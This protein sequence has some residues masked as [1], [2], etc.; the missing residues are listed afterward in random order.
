MKASFDYDEFGVLGSTEGMDSYGNIFAYTGHVY[1]DSTGIYYAKARYYDSD[2]GRFISEDSYKGEIN[3]AVTL[4]RYIYTLNNPIIY[5]DPSGNIVGIDDA[6]IFLIFAVG[7]IVLVTY[8]YLLTPAGKN[9]INSGAVA[10]YKGRVIAGKI[11][12][13][14]AKLLFQQYEQ[15]QYRLEIRLLM[16]LPGLEIK[17][18]TVQHGLAIKLVMHGEA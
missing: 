16:E 17:L 14:A 12:T 13:K 7:S 8:T 3:S 6:I 10:V 9:A 2:N 1:D 5:T 15:E 4:N 18:M 11:I